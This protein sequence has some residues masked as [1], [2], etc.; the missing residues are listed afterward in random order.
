M[1]FGTE[2]L[3]GWYRWSLEKPWLFEMVDW[4]VR[5]KATRALPFARQ[6]HVN[7]TFDGSRMHLITWR[8]GTSDH[9]LH[10]VGWWHFPKSVVYPV[11][12]S[13]GKKGRHVH[14]SL[15]RLVLGCLF[16]VVA[17]GRVF[18]NFWWKKLWVHENQD[19]DITHS[20]NQQGVA[21]FNFELR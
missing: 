20:A 10:N 7:Y 16:H 8:P 2:G 17:I 4:N 1:P 11:S 15:W 3:L 14:L 12:I 5:K 13:V 19:H 18:W 6:F 9:V 21:S